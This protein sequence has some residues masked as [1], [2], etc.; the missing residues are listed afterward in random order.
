DSIDKVGNPN[1]CCN[2]SLK[3]SIV[4]ATLLEI[5]NNDLISYIDTVKEYIIENNK[6]S[7]LTYIHIK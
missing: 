2:F 5:S 3:S 6:L 7:K 1:D 4:P